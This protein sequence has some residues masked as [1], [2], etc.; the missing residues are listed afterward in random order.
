MASY[1][2]F[3][4]DKRKYANSYDMTKRGRNPIKKKNLKHEAE[5]N[6]IHWVT[7]YRRNIHRFV[8]H[9]FGIELYLYQKTLLY[10]MNL[11]TLVVVVAC[12]AAAKSYLI[13]IYACARCV[14]YPGSRVVVASA[15]KKQA[16]LIVT[17]KI[18]KELIPNSPTLAR[19]IKG[20]KTNSQDIEVFFHNGSSF[21][22]VPASDNARGYR[23]TTMIYEEFRMIKKEII[24]SVL[25]PFLFVRQAPYLKNPKYSHLKEEPIEIYISSAWM[26]QHWMWKHIK[27]AVKSMYENFDS[28]LIGFDYAITLKHGIRTKKQLE[29][30]K[31]KM[32]ATTFAIEYENIMLGETENAYYTYDLLKKNQTLKKAFYP[33]KHIDVIEKRK[34]K[35]DIP[36]KPGEIRIVPVDIAMISGSQ[37]DNTAI[38]CI[39][40]LPVKNYYER[41]LCYMES[42]NGGNTTEQAIRIKQIFS[43]FNADYLVLDTQNSGISV[44]DELGKVLYDEERDLEY[45]PWTCFNDEK[46]AERIKNPNALPVVYSIKAYSSLNHQIHK[47]MKD[48]LERGKFK[49][50]INSIEAEDFLDKIKEYSTGDGI[51]QANFLL[52]YVQIEALINEMV[53][54][55]YEINKNSNT[56]KLIEPRN[57]RKDRYTSV[58]YGN[59]FIQ[60]LEL[61]LESQSQSDYDFTFFYN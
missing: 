56:I 53:N 58:S 41:Q 18:Q 15:T 49:L 34:N 42:M 30:E 5:E 13:A 44:F 45:E 26:K 23:A 9:Y 1:K 19:E 59:Y 10:L 37:N 29:K 60:Q 12:R 3:Q 2:N 61:D 46:T 8:E 57:A 7:F 40:A 22:V 20:I 11:C 16:K 36:K 54:L 47:Y 14:L 21:V 43:D 4:N 24:D 39:R 17:E 27:L 35:F 32:G 25:S 28:L 51:T 55:S 38:G 6:L 33:R 31:K 48:A 52:P 50:L